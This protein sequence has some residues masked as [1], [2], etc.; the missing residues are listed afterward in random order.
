MK[1]IP[2]LLAMAALP[3]LAATHL[4]PPAALLGC[5]TSSRSENHW[6]DGKVTPFQASCT[7]FFA[8]TRLQVSCRA[9]DGG[10][11]TQTLFDYTLASPDTF[12]VQLVTSGKDA[13]VS[14]YLRPHE[15]TLGAGQLSISS[16]T[17]LPKDSAGR[18]VTKTVSRFKP[19]TAPDAASCQP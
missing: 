4:A 3:T 14:N 7:R 8:A 6:D 1:S 13:Y 17:R 2:L 10:P 18:T 15:F 16:Y 9:P 11:V 19:G 12:T 5:W